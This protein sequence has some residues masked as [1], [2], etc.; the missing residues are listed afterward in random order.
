MW[1]GVGGVLAGGGLV[2]LGVFFHHVKLENADRWASVIGVFVGLTSLALL[3]ID[4]ISARRTSAASDGQQVGEV[5]GD[6]YQF[7]KVTG[8]LRVGS[9]RT[10]PS[11]QPQ[12]QAGEGPAEAPGQRGGQSAGRVGGRNVQADSVDG[13]V[14]IETEGPGA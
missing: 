13:G 6:N 8:G 10:L 12:S 4:F 3:I 9:P 7:R 11:P 14:E 1:W 2:G 5:D